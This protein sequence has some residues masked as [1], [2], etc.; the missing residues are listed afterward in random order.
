M[1]VIPDYAG[2]PGV[3]T[4]TDVDLVIDL[5]SKTP[6][7][8]QLADRIKA[9]IDSGEL[10]PEQ[11]VPSFKQL[12]EQTGLAMGTVQKA[13]RLLEREHRVYTVSGRGTFVTSHRADW[14]TES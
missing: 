11:P 13:I 14:A 4:V 2:T 8:V 6:S 7:Y 9:A 1:P 3:A 10:L 5:R 12:I